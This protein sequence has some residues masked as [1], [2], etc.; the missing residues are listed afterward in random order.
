MS[1]SLIKN[2]QVTGHWTEKLWIYDFRTN[3]HFTLKTGT[4]KYED[5]KDFIQCYNPENRHRRK[6]TE[7]FK[8]FTYDELLKRDKVNL[9]IFGLEMKVLKIQII[10][11][12]QT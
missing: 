10:F 4:L 1:C 6:E 7:R 3:K 11:L 2:Q 9:D 5:L 12:H 8:S